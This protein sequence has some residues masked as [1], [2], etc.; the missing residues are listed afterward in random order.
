VRLEGVVDLR[1]SILAYLQFKRLAH[2]NLNSELSL[3]Y[4]AGQLNVLKDLKRTNQ[5]VSFGRS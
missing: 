1:Y 4:G 2:L 5:I 3:Y